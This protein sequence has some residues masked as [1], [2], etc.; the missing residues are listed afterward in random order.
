MCSAYW[1]LTNVRFT[2]PNCGEDE[3]DTLQTHFMGETGSC[4]NYYALGEVVPELEVVS[5]TLDGKNDGLIGKCD[6]CDTFID[7]GAIIDAGRVIAVWPLAATRL[8]NRSEE[9]PNGEEGA[10]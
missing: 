6:S 1:N 4:A 2:C 8:H 7:F 5:V 10:R 9:R 3:T